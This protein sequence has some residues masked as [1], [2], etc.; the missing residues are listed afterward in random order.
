MEIV[1]G[2]K[3]V[4]CPLFAIVAADEKMLSGA[5]STNYHIEC[6]ALV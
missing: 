4:T 1:S 2:A 6:L 5:S 3:L